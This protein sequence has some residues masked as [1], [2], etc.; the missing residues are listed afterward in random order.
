MHSKV[1]KENS[2][3]KTLILLTLATALSAFGCI[4]LGYLFLPFAAATYAA[5]LFYENKTR[6]II[7]IILPVVFL[8]LNCAL[9]GFFSAEGVVYVVIGLLIYLFFDRKKS[10]TEAIAWL[11]ILLTLFILISAVLFAFDANESAS[12]TALADYYYNLYTSQKTKFIDYFSSLAAKDTDGVAYFIYTREYSENLFHSF[13]LLLPSLIVIIAFAL[14]GFTLKIFSSLTLKITGDE[15]EIAKWTFIPSK[16]ISITYIVLAVI[17]MFM[18]STDDIF[19]ISLVN[20]YY[21]LLSVFAYFGFKFIYLLI[22]ARKGGA[23]AVFLVLIAF[24]LIGTNTVLL[25][26]YIGVYYSMF[27]QKQLKK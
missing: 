25:L 16:P 14:A 6:R 20:I 5:L 18:D 10:K 4:L 2:Y 9:N 19:S 27:L 21:I 15:L 3:T 23:Y 7:S 8:V 11:T 12:F 24:A 22:S 26:S 1:K 17:T 13:V